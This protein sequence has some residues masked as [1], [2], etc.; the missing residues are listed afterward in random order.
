VRAG[1]S[2]PARRRRAV[3]MRDAVCAYYYYSAIAIAIA[4]PRSSVKKTFAI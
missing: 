3:M 2:R 1:G 4:R